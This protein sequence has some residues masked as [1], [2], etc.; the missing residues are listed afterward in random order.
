MVIV[1]LLIDNKFG[2]PKFFEKTFV[3]AD[4]SI[5]VALEILFLIL[6]NTKINFID[7]KLNSRLYTII[8]TLLITKEVVLV[9]IKEFAVATLD[10]DDKTFIAHI[11]SLASSNLNVYLFFRA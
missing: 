9:K 8:K 1:F 4:V 5:N 3:L 11:S 2:I 7:C 10:L 6:S